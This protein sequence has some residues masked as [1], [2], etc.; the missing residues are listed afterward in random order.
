MPKRD[1]KERRAMKLSDRLSMAMQ[2]LLKR[3]L[4]TLLTVLGVVIGIASIVI[5]IALGEG[6]NLK[7]MAEI[8]KYGGLRTITV[9]EGDNS[10]NTYSSGNTKTSKDAL[11]A[12][13]TDS[14]VESIK[15][16]E[17][18]AIASPVLNFQCVLKSGQYEN[19]VW[20]GQAMSLEALNDMKWTFSEGE[21]P[22]EG[23]PLKFIYGNLV[24]EDFRTATGQTYYDTNEMP[25]IDLMKDP[26]FTVFDVDAYN[27]SKSSAVPDGAAGTS[28]S[29]SSADGTAVTAPPK[30]Y[31][32]PAAGVL[33]G[34]GPDDYSDYSYNVYCDIDAL[35]SQYRK[36]F[37]NKAIPGQPVKENGSPYKQIYY[38]SIY[39][40]VDTVDNV[41]PVQQA[42]NDMGYNTQSQ[43]EWVEQTKEQSRAMQ[44][45][46]GGIG[47]VSLLV[48]A[49]GI[50]NTMMMSIYERTREIGIM[51]VLGCDLRDIQS[52]FLLE[53]AFIGLTG[54][55]AGIALSYLVSLVIN[56]VTDAQTSVIPL[57]LVPSAMVFAVFVG[58]AAGYAPSK[59]AMQLSPLA[60]IRNE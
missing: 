4:R 2:S 43:T 32:I 20:S 54:G 39:V 19:D 21:L 29:G 36:T 30:K 35:I 46:L 55:V 24:L 33:Y 25:D 22:K 34:S 57:W 50:A 16:M 17:H 42:I 44:A 1:Q 51:K 26:M 8:E 58:M 9:T 52:L 59:R 45:M 11:A 47:A 6:M 5:M 28:D 13:L 7:S 53:A 3:R 49:I 40:K 18:V 14:T 37:R 10:Q 23:D 60:A 31:I 27:S 38:S 15:E 56:L 41:A 12:K 48:A